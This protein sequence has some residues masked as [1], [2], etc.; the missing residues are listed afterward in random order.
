MNT[1]PTSVRY[2]DVEWVVQYP[3]G[4]NV[5]ETIFN[6]LRAANVPFEEC[7]LWYTTA[8]WIWGGVDQSAVAAGGGEYGPSDDIDETLARNEAMLV[9]ASRWVTV[10]PDFGGACYRH[11]L[12][13]LD[14]RGGITLPDPAQL[15]PAQGRSVPKPDVSNMTPSNEEVTVAEYT[16]EINEAVSAQRT[17]MKRSLMLQARFL[18]EFTTAKNGVGAAYLQQW[19]LHAEVDPLAVKRWIDTGAPVNGLSRINY[20]D[21]F[22]HWE[23]PL[24]TALVDERVNVADSLLANGANV[25]AANF[26]VDEKNVTLAHTALHMMSARADVESVRYLLAAGASANRRT[27][28]GATPL[29]LAAAEDDPA[30]VL[31]LLDAGANPA[32]TDFF[33]RT[34][35]SRSGERTRGLLE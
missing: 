29:S 2:P 20:G 11:Y 5:A 13:V 35:L 19:G 16:R 18:Q 32:D 26:Y 1:S 14:R 21:G 3:G 23:T 10:L 31:L 6:L 4:L 30:T 33:G 15:K 28:E 17:Y 22:E 8:S 7:Q 12:D 27:T 9:H 24:L 25:D 34:P